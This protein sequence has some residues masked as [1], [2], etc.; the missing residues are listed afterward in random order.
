MDLRIFNLCILLGWLMVS[1]G[2][3]L[4][5]GLGVGVATGG[6]LLLLLT[7]VGAYMG[8]ISAPK[9]PA[10]GEAEGG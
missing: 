3:A 10:K 6:G 9:K 1:G 8:G 5:K 2:V 7:M 4:E